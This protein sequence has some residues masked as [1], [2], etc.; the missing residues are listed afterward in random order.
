MIGNVSEAFQ[1]PAHGCTGVMDMHNSPMPVFTMVDLCL[2]SL[3]VKRAAV[4]PSRCDEVPIELRL[5]CIAVHMNCDVP[6][7]EPSDREGSTHQVFD[8]V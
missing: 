4:L 2:H 8:E 6:R 7:C 3:R 5:G 1:I